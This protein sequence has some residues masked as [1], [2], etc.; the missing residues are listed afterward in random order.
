MILTSAIIYTGIY[1]V[2]FDRFR[3]DAAAQDSVPLSVADLV[4]VEQ[5]DYGRPTTCI[6]PFSWA[7]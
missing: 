6:R 4:D 7:G 1:M 5:N 3:P 2:R